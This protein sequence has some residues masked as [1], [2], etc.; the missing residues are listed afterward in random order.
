ML[1]KRLNRIF[2]INDALG[3]L[4]LYYYRVDSQVLISREVRFITSFL[5]DVEFDRMALAQYLLFRYQLG[6]RTLI[7]NIH[8][9]KPATL[10]QIDADTGHMEMSTIFQFNFDDDKYAKVRIKENGDN[11]VSLFNDACKNRAATGRDYTNI[12]GLSGGLDSR[13]VGASFKNHQVPFCGA[14]LLDYNKHFALDAKI[15]EL[16]ACELNIDWRLFNLNAPKGKDLSK[17]LLMKNGLNYLGMS[18]IFDFFKKIKHAFGDKIVYHTGDGGQ[19][20]KPELRAA[21]KKLRSLEESVEYLIS[22]NKLFSPSVVAQLTDLPEKELIEEIRTLF[23]SYPEKQWNNKYRHFMIYEVDV[24]H[25]FEGE[26][27]NRYFS[28]T[29]T[30]FYSIPFFQYAMNCPDKQVAKYSL[31]RAFLVKLSPTLAEIDYDRWMM[32]I[33]SKKINLIF[34]YHKIPQGVKMSI[35]SIFKSPLTG[36]NDQASI[37]KCF[38]E[39]LANCETINDYFEK[40]ALLKIMTNCSMHQFDFLFTLA[41]SIEE[42]TCKRSTIEH[43]REAVFI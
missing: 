28:W 9:L 29:S 10:M 37:V 41:S 6:E 3:R 20:L 15:A 35:R 2:F 11:L 18:F 40:S 34:L 1:D 8:R 4:P 21:S 30:P 31:Y 7:K 12:L 32:P 39:Q 5:K 13:A 19:V 42:F 23:L 26:D 33:T 17:L 43:H 14:T 36:Y 38:R 22:K 27:R 16:V 25:N 24:N